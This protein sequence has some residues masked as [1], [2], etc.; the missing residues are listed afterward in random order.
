MTAGAD[1]RHQA[2]AAAARTALIVAGGTGGHIMPGLAVADELLAR[3]WRV[4][5]LGHP[6]KMEGRLV[7]AHGLPLEP[8]RFA[9]VRGKGVL[10]LVKLPVTLLAGF[11]QAWRA[12]RRVRPHVLLGMGGYVAFPAGMMAVLRGVPLVVHEQ[13]AI[14]GLANRLLAGV[15][16]RVLNGF[17]GALKG[18]VAVGNPVRASVQA[19]PGPAQRYGARQGP[20]RL[21]V[22]GGSLGAQAL[23]QTLPQALARLPQAQRPIVVHQSGEAHLQALRQAYDQAGVQAQ[24]EAFITDMAAALADADLVICR[25]GAMTVAE[26]A[27]AGVAALFVPFPHAVDD[28]QTVNARYLSDH[29]AAWLQPQ[30]SFTAQWLAAWLGERRRDELQAVA[31]RARQR[32]VPDSAAKIADACEQAARPAS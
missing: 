25:A 14:A 7:P 21:L 26:V 32:A 31:E 4:V 17:P 23:N 9:G 20:L 11:A 8:L 22:V 6:E 19:L 15:A 13:N 16:D 24:C 3:G 1:L 5:W 10:A 29:G 12:L 27:A 30:P 28:H 2:A 18:S